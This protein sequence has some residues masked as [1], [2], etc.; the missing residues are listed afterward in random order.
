MLSS[1]WLIV[2]EPPHCQKVAPFLLLPA[3][4]ASRVLVKSAATV[5]MGSRC[6]LSCADGR[7]H[8]HVR[9]HIHRSYLLSLF[10][11]ESPCHTAWFGFCPIAFCPLARLKV[12]APPYE[13]SRLVSLSSRCS[14]WLTVKRVFGLGGYDS[15]LGYGRSRV[16]LAEDPDFFLSFLFPPAYV[17]HLAQI[18]RCITYAVSCADT[19]TVCRGPTLLFAN[20]LNRQCDGLIAHLILIFAMLA[21]GSLALH[22]WIFNI[23]IRGFP[24]ICSFPL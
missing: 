10:C 6:R 4:S 2:G 12:F 9:I 23:S 24:L 3:F 19:R 1:V 7:G 21:S 18:M 13:V 16:R 20:G 22:R 15:R 11:T 5:T 8:F 14:E 17:L